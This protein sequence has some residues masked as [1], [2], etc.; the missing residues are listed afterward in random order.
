MYDPT[1]KNPNHELSSLQ[2]RIE[3]A[4]GAD[5][6]LDA[7]I[8]RLIRRVVNDPPDADPDPTPDAIPA[9]TASVDQC[10][11]LLHVVLPDWHWHI[12]RDA[13]GVFPYAALSKGKTVIS[14]DGTSVPLVLL[15]AMIRAVKVPE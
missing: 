13:S 7:D 10:L 1:M 4:T 9:Y 5:R 14:A 12:G 6:D 11:E 8:D 15:T 3:A 2:Q